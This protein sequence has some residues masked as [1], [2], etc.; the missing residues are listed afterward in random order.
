MATQRRYVTTIP[1]PRGDA[2]TPRT[3]TYEAADEEHLLRVAATA[4]DHDAFA[5]LYRRSRDTV[6]RYLMRRTS[7]DRHLAEDLTHET[8]VRAL[9]RIG[10]YQEMGRPF[11]A[12]LLTI[13]GNLVADHYKSGWRRLQVP[14]SDFAHEVDEG[15]NRL[16]WTDTRDDLATAVTDGE[17]RRHASAVLARAMADL[18]DW[19]QRVVRLRYVEGLSVRDTAQELDVED[20]A[21]KAATYRA[22]RTLAQ[23][24]LVKP[25]WAE[26]RSAPRVRVRAPEP[27]T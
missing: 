6:F 14:R 15:Q 5:V 22:M 19:Q 27:A 25:L 2:V 10:S 23:H 4:G 26:R 11:V 9:A 8:F 3:R 1:N 16:M 7:G 21:V 13:A 17:Y 12:W 18:T 24:P 20:G